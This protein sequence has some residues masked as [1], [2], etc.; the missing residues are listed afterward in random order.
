[1]LD[2]LFQEIVVACTRYKDKRFCYTFYVQSIF[3]DDCILTNEWPLRVFRL[4]DKV[5]VLA[6]RFRNLYLHVVVQTRA[7]KEPLD[8]T[9]AKER[10]L[11]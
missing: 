8:L 3:Q 4:K 6:Q 11:S 5:K 7:P 1:M 10:S 2:K 9:A